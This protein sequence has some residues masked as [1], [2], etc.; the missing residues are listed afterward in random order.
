MA[1]VFSPQQP[2]MTT[3]DHGSI[4]HGAPRSSLSHRPPPNPPFVFPMQP[5]TDV[6]NS[7]EGP[8]STPSSMS[9]RRAKTRTRP[10][11]LSF[12]AL[13]EFSFHPSP[14]SNKTSDPDTPSSTSKNQMVPP[15]HGGHRR[16]GSEFIGGDG[17]NAI[18]GLMSTSP[19]KGEGALPPPPGARTGP[20]AG[21]RG[22]A[23]RRSGAIS[24]HDVSTILKPTTEIRSGSAP[25]TPSDPLVQPNLPPVLDRSISQPATSLPLQESSPASHHRHASSTTSHPRPRVGFSDHVEFIPRPLST[26]SSET[27]S[28]LSTI[29]PGHS[30]TG[31]ISSVISAG[32][33]SPPSS[34][35]ARMLAA[36]NV[37]EG[38]AAT[39]ETSQ[40]PRPMSQS[41]EQSPE[42]HSISVADASR[43]TL[44]PEGSNDLPT[45]SEVF[46]SPRPERESDNHKS[47][48]D[49]P[50]LLR[51][52]GTPD[53]L[54]N[55]RR[56]L[57]STTSLIARPR[58]SPEP[59][60]SKRQ[61]KVKSWA[62]SLLARKARHSLHEDALNGPGSPNLQ[63]SSVFTADLSLENLNFDEDPTCII[64]TAPRTAK[65]SS[66]EY[67]TC[68]AAESSPE[69]D[70]DGSDQVLDLDAVYS[71]S[72]LS[73]SFE[74]VIGSRNVGT[75]RR[76]H[77]SGAT[78]GFDG[79]GMH[80]HRR[81]ESAPELAPVN[82]HVFGIARLGSNSAMEDV[83]EEDE[84]DEVANQEKGMKSQEL[85]TIS[86][87]KSEHAYGFGVANVDAGNSAGC[88]T[89][90]MQ[91]S[92]ATPD[93]QV[94]YS[95]TKTCTSA[96]PTAVPDELRAIE[97]VDAD[98]EPR[99]ALARKSYSKSAVTPILA[100]DPFL[101]RPMSAPMQYTL[102]APSP[103]FATPEIYS[104]AASTPDFSQTSFEGSR[105][106]TASSSITDRGTLSS[107]RAGD[108]GFDFRVSV[109]DV[110]S[111]T[112]SASTMTNAYPPRI[113]SSAVTRTS[114]DRPP[115]PSSIVTPR[116]RPENASKR[117]S[118]A[119][120]SR[121][122][123][124]SYGERSK[125]N[126]EERAHPED[127]ERSE[128]KKGKRISRLMRFWKS[129]EKVVSS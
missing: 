107:F 4:D 87:G 108:Q 81:T 78:G 120:L 6:G 31:S 22:H 44:E 56:P 3:V 63:T 66:M 39:L 49:A 99:A 14:S 2:F 30:V 102:P 86:T 35:S 103:A 98:E 76:L 62:G 21:R 70:T 125:L 88:L 83:F 127:M 38:D 37:D 94:D 1:D 27:S 50:S 43:T 110:P 13:P 121:L 15:H 106:H 40:L 90:R 80:Y 45:W 100:D 97:I 7:S 126:I 84:E 105:L 64:D 47:N 77:S 19:T 18:T 65:A 33:A 36:D 109:D 75:R 32:T 118:L 5:E 17:K 28:S 111:L 74:E 8:D 96:T 16:N 89:S 85:E 57:S 113:S 119:S 72:S 51:L 11:Q 26:I 92:A 124:G 61:R 12:N 128:K 123:G 20:P 48:D 59:K 79:P 112:S 53:A 25:T 54:W 82:R 71:P 10:Q 46:K 122:V 117:S 114:A 58:T 24:N 34:K 101:A 42:E 73:P 55:R 115:S 91:N 60:V 23:H 104:S 93:A 52:A 116:T 69:S 41:G 67:P 129:K 68:D 95:E 29:R 9:S